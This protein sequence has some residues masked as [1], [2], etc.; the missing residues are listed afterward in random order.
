[1]IPLG[2]VACSPQA[3]MGKS[4]T[5]DLESG[6]IISRLASIPV[7]L[8]PKNIDQVDSNADY[9]LVWRSSGSFPDHVIVSRS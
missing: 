5:R 7:D 8:R 1:M 9:R 6:E 3:L 2:V 4:T